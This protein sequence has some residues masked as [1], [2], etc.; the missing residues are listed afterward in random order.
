MLITMFTSTSQHIPQIAAAIAGLTHRAVVAID[1]R[2]GAGKTSFA[3]AL[4]AALEAAGAGPVASMEVESFIEGWDGLE[5]GVADLAAGPIPEFRETGACT[6]R[7][8]DWHSGAWGETVRVPETGHG[9][10][11]LL[12]GC[13]SASAPLAPLLDYSVWIEAPADVRRDRVRRREGDPAQW[14]Q[15]WE[16][17][18]QRLLATLDS[19]AAATWRVSNR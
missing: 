4:T 9:R 10:V 6:A 12:V 14:W 17:Q 2:T 3:G 11:L 7:R 15:M 1:G 13:G 5:R 8:W 16:G 18:H 19:R